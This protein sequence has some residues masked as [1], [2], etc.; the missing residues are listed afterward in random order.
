MKRTVKLA[1]YVVFL[2]F[3][4]ERNCGSFISIFT[5]EPEVWVPVVRMFTRRAALGIWNGISV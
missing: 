2:N 4:L 3:S 1:L 5:P